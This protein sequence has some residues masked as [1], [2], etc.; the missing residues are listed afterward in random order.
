M[1]K[2]Q[3]RWGENSR[4]L[5]ILAPKNGMFCLE[6]KIPKKI[7]D[8]EAV[9]FEVIPHL[10]REPGQF[11]PIRPEEPFAYLSRLRKAHMERRDGQAGIVLE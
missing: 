9:R 3:V 5:G 4:Q 8:S 2:V 1:C 11:V 10:R 6:T 7:F